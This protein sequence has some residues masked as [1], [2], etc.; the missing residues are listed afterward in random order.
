MEWV[1]CDLEDR[2]NGSQGGS[3]M[4]LGFDELKM[5]QRNSVDI[6]SN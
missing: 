4:A 2:I 1:K 3:D 6:H 5:Q